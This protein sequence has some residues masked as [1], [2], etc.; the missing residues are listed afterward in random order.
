MAARY[1]TISDNIINDIDKGILLVDKRMPSLRQFT[2]LHNVSMTTA[3]NCY[4]R[5]L[6][7]GWLYAKPKIGY[8]ITQPLNKQN[9]PI[10]PQFNAQVATPKVDQSIV[11]GLRGQ[12]Y[13][14]Q[15]PEDL[16]P[17]DILNRCLRRVNQRIGSDLFAYPDH[18]GDVALRSALANHFSQQHLPLKSDNLVITNG[19]IDA[20][21]SAIEITT[22]PGDTV[23]IS[24]PCFNGLLNLLENMGRLVL[25]IPCYQSQLD[26]DQLESLLKDKRIS[27]C[28]FSAN[29]INPQGFCL[30]NQQKQRIAELATDYQVPVIE[31]DICLELSYSNI[32]PLSIKYWD[33][34]GWVLWCS[35][36]SKTIAGGYRLG[37]CE[38]G[39]FFN[40]YLQLR[41]VQFF[42]VN[43]IV[44][45][46]V[47][48]FINTG[49]YSKHLKKLTATLAA[50]ARQYH[51]LLRELL[52]KNTKI[53]VPEGGMVIWLQL[54]NMDSQSVLNEALKKGISFRAGSEFTTLEYYQNCLRL[55]IG[56]S[57]VKNEKDS[58]EKQEKS[59]ALRA[60]LICLCGLINEDVT[61]I[62]LPLI[63]KPE[64]DG[65]K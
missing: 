5:L 34:S 12:F 62:T 59:L 28:L 64:P 3:N 35:S 30:S 65:V 14:A 9:T 47:C 38:P 50:H 17:Q 36:V 41:S 54:D 22:N 55:N 15:L 49:H 58:A 2:Q 51:S 21:R 42:G 39:R 13:T 46:T 25:E 18:Q 53:S 48:E 61:S 57:I 20:V 27:V 31:D 19:C 63:P 56:W 37:W 6:D 24:S 4:Q 29:H 16:I 40:A 7:L 33:K 32:T 1:I 44:Q 11:Q 26:L 23:A 10:Y 60:Q 8:F 52:P 45:H 43:N